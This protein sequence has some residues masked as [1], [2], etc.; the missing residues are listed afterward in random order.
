MSMMKRQKWSAPQ[1]GMP[2]EDVG[3]SSARASVTGETVSFYYSNAGV[4]TVDAGQ[5]VATVVEAV[6][7]YAPIASSSGDQVGVPENSSLS[8]T[9]TA[10]TNEIRLSYEDWE[11]VDGVTF[12]QKLS[13][14]QTFVANKKTADAN[15]VPTV[16]A[17]GDYVVDYRHGVLIGKKASTQT[18]LASVAYKTVQKANISTV[19]QSTASS[20]NAQVVGNVASASADSGNPVKVGLKVNVTSPTFT[21]GN[22][23]DFQGDINGYLKDREQYAAAAEDNTYGV[24]AEAIKPLSTSAYSWSL[25][26]NFGANTTLNVKATTGNVKS[27]Y[28][29]NTN[30]AIRYIQLHNTATTP[31]GAAVPV[32]T[33]LIPASG[34]VVID[35]TVL[36][37]N[38]YNFST[39]I[40]FAYSTT[41]FTYTAATA[42]EQCTIIMFK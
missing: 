18:T 20:L 28:C 21:D 29:H 39:G 30:A 1:R 24:F 12:A 41:E 10:F 23:A 34:T 26:T 36:G 4:R 8:F 16:M 13:L 31:A 5:A 2:T 38:G 9:S 35:G 27:I 11:Q 7:A 6:L 22:R 25:F 33:Y 17:N 3:G 19:S 14:I 42:G 32:L 37:E 15:G 40:A